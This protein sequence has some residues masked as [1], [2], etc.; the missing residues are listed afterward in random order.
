[1]DVKTNKF[2]QIFLEEAVELLKPF[3]ARLEAWQA[4]P[5][6]PD[7]LE[8]F[9]RLAHTLKTDSGM[10]GMNSMKLFCRELELAVKS[11]RM[12]KRKAEPA[13]IGRLIEEYRFLEENLRALEQ[14]PVENADLL[15]ARRHEFA[16][17]W[18]EDQ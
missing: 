11:I 18:G 6:D 3:E 13:D 16:A 1:M 10:V 15:E 14:N 17:Y 12:E 8:Y 7:T 9:H 2:I 5:T 4:N